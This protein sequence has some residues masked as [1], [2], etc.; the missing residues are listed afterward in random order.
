[1]PREFNKKTQ[2][3]EKKEKKEK[4]KKKKKGRGR[5]FLLQDVGRPRFL[6][7][8]LFFLQTTAILLLILMMVDVA[9][10]NGWTISQSP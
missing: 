6:Q 8:N 1:L 2:E 4:K 3:N 10:E 7:S 5:V 9:D